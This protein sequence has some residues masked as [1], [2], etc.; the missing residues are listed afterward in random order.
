MRWW[1][2]SAAIRELRRGRV[3]AQATEG[4]F[5]LGC[6]AFDQGACARLAALKGRAKNKRFIV[7]VAD[8]A[9]ISRALHPQGTALEEVL[10]SWPGPETWVF[11]VAPAAPRWLRGED[12]T[13][14]V[15]VTA[16][17]QLARI[18]AAVGPIVSTSA[19]PPGRKPALNLARVRGY[20]GRK[21]DFYLAGDLITPGRATR[22]RDA[23]SG[24]LLR[25]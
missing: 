23:R 20:F 18:C 24:L 21:V 9:Q 11:P 17:R 25:R 12:R 1:L 5:G 3:I 7:V 15:R 22:I 2:E 6:R 13:I 14:A 4:V 8:F 10:A 19:N 16:H